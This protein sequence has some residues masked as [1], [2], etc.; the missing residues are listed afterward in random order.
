MIKKTLWSLVLILFLSLIE[1]SILANIS[2]LPVIP[3]LVMI[4]LLYI[5]FY[6]GQIIGET[7][8]FLSGI[9][10]DFISASPLGLN[11]FVR[12]VQGFVFGFVR[13]NINLGRFFAPFLIGVS[14]TLFKAL[15]T[16]ILSFFFGSLVIN[17]SIFSVHLWLETLANGILTPVLFFIFDFFPVLGGGNST[18]F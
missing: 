10:L 13:G 3:D 12:T 9:C 5:S 11:A 15:V 4:F 16:W 8:G 1:S 7:T 17:Y 14:G 2:F 18:E 6:N